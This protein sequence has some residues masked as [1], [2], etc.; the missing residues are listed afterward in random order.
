[1]EN[2]KYT[3]SMEDGIKKNAP[4]WAKKEILNGNDDPALNVYLEKNL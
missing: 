3:K 2:K 4:E 1:M